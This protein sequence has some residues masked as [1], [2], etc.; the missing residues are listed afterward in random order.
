MVTK[1]FKDVAVNQEFVFNG[2]TYRKL[3]EK[4]IS[5]CRAI[6]ACL[7]ENPNTTTQVK[8]IEEVQVNE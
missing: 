2:L 8:P 5:C 4:R 1:Q 6:N 7:V 3:E